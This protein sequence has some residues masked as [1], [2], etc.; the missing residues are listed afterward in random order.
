[1][2][3]CGCCE[4]E[5]EIEFECERCGRPLCAYCLEGMVAAGWV[6]RVCWACRGKKSS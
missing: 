6:G 3:V 2:F 4:E 5:R 1:M